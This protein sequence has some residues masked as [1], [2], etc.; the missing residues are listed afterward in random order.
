[1]NGGERDVSQQWSWE[2]L[3]KGFLDKWQEISAV[4]IFITTL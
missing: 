2:V 1:M 3:L 4:C